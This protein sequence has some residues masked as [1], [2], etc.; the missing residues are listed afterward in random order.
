M[1]VEI[2]NRIKYWRQEDR[3]SPENPLTHWKL[4]F[5]SAMFKLCKKK[6][7]HFGENSELRPHV[8]I[9]GCSNISIGKNVVIRP[10]SM[11]LT[12]SS[13][14]F[15]GMGSITIEDNVLFGPDVKMFTGKH[16]F[17]DPVVPIIDQGL[18][19][20]RNILIKE[21]SWIGAGVIILPGVTVGSNSVVGSGSVVN[22]DVPDNV[23]V[24]GVPAKMVRDLREEGL[25]RNIEY[26]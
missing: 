24:V 13:D 21:G 2:W 12:N 4:Y 11:L 3:I 1:L 9:G 10:S 7:K 14:Q 19:A 18:E 26:K 20:P 8:F 16:S 15:E 17:S 25:N 5:R 6:F 23:L 22:K